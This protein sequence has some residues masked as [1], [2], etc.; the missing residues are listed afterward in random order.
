VFF[1]T[2]IELTVKPGFADPESFVKVFRQVCRDAGALTWLM[3][4]Q[5]KEI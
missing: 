5:G 3:G 2:G 4:G 1:Y